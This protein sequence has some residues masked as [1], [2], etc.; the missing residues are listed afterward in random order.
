M[1]IEDK[2]SKLKS[3]DVNK[4]LDEALKEIEEFI[5][6]LNREQ[7]YE[8]GQIDVNN[9]G[10][11]EQYAESTKKQKVKRAQFKKTEFVTLRWN[12][13][14][15]DSYKLIIFEKEF[16]ISATDLKWANYLEGNPRFGNALGLTEES[17]TKLRAEI[18]PIIVKKIK[19][20]L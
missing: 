3:I 6:D 11:R 9:P 2:I 7:L 4:I 16:I 14:F 17:K 20:E 8:R 12:G 10:T 1:V 18:L 19:D 13:D 15:Y 5:L